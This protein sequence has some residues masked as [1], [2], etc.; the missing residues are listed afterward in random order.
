MSNGEQC[1]AL[2]ICCPPSAAKRAR[3]AD[4][5]AAHTG[6]NAAHAVLFL[7]WMDYEG[8]IFAPLSARAFIDEIAT[9]AKTHAKDA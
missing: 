3:L 4:A 2:E 7:D 8:L 9:M 6:A 5:I 1:C